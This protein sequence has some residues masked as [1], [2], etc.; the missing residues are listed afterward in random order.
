MQKMDRLSTIRRRCTTLPLYGWQN[1]P[2]I[3]QTVP[4]ALARKLSMVD[5]KSSQLV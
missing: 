5:E 3:H 1:L 4:P 2:D